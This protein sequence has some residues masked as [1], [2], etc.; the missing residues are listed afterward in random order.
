MQ[1]FL[2]GSEIVWKD[3]PESVA[4]DDRIHRQGLVTRCGE[5]ETG[6]FD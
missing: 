4:D 5:L 2:K 1:G 6:A 3:M